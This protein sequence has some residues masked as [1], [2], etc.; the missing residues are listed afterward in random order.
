M[1]ILTISVTL[2]FS[3]FLFIPFAAQAAL[4]APGATLDPACGPTDANCGIATSIAS[5]TANS[6]P[7][8]SANGSLLSATSTIQ[9]LPNGTASTSGA[10]LSKTT[11]VGTTINSGTI[12]GG[13]V[14]S[15]IGQNCTTI[16]DG[17]YTSTIIPTN[18][19]NGGV[20]SIND[21]TKIKLDTVLANTDNT[22]DIANSQ[23]KV[24]AW[25]KYI[26]VY[27]HMDFPEQNNGN[28]WAGLHLFRNDL[29]TA[30]AYYHTQIYYPTSTT[31]IKWAGKVTSVAISPIIPVLN[32]NETWQ[33]YA[34][35]STGGNVTV[36]SPGSWLS[37][38]F[39]D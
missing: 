11:L 6:I 14:T 9:I 25:A 15:R 28:G 29:Y 21:Y 30:E 4:Y 20:F 17:N 13:V 19:Q 18:P 10:T 5:G 33:L 7:Y 38:C 34:E 35:Q 36:S 2:L 32:T 3:I 8:Y 31:T 24:P 23:I 16:V 37:V 26:Q 27:G 22:A 39:Y 1:R 12:S